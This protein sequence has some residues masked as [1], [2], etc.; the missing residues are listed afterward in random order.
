MDNRTLYSTKQPVVERNNYTMDLRSTAD[1]LT[2]SEQKRLAEW[3]QTMDL[4]YG[5]RVSID[6]PMASRASRE[7]VAA[8]AG[9]YGLLVEDGAP[10]T[11]GYVN[12]GMI[13]VVVSRSRA[14]VPGC[15]DWS[16]RYGANYNNATNDG[17]GCAINSNIAAMIA[18]PEHLLKGADQNETNSVVSSREAVD[19]YNSQVSIGSNGSTGG[20]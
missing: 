18:D 16:G 9:R 10:V 4:R 19:S 1:G 7:S 13:R 5:D 3:F 15:P 14:Y 11:E 6:D 2:I 8:L 20:Y 12:P 17:Y